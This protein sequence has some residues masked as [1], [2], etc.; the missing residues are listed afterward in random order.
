VWGLVYGLED[1]DLAALDH[2][3]DVPHGY[4]R[5]RGVVLIA[6]A[7]DFTAVDLNALIHEVA[8]LYEGGVTQ[9]L[10]LDL[11]P[12]LPAVEADRSRLR[13]VLHNLIKN[14]L[15]AQ[16]GRALRRVTVTT[17]APGPGSGT[18]ELRVADAGPGIPEEM[19]EGVFQPYM[20]GKPRGSGLG[21]AIVK[22][23]IEEHGGTVAAEN[24]AEGGAA[25]RVHLPVSDRSVQGSAA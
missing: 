7:A 12:G 2:Y 21:L 14:A 13:Q 19:L 20:T 8:D 4:E 25:V 11:D 9:A 1:N 6:P 17:R 23:I 18:V 3:E 15:E 16:E 24:S 10:T 5:V 22:K